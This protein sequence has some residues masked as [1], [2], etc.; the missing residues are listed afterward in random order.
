MGL[1]DF[2]SAATNTATTAAGAQQAGQYQ[3]TMAQRNQAIQAAMLARQMRME[4]S[5]E[6]YREAQGRRADAAAKYY[7]KRS[8]WGPPGAKGGRTAVLPDNTQIE[9]D[10]KNPGHWFKTVMEP[11]PE[12]APGQQSPAGASQQPGGAPSPATPP[13]T[14]GKPKPSTNTPGGNIAL[15]PPPP[16]PQYGA[17]VVTVNPDGTRTYGIP[18]RQEP[19][20]IE[21]TTGAPD[22]NAAGQGPQV[23]VEDMQRLYDKVEKFS[24]LYKQNPGIV[25]RASQQREGLDYGIA[26]SSS[27]GKTAIGKS[28]LAGASDY[29]SKIGIP[30]ANTD[31]TTA[32]GKQ[33][34][35]YKEYMTNHRAL[36]DDIAK[37]FR[38]RQNEQAV[39][40]EIAM[41][42]FQP[43]DTP[44]QIDDKL[45][46][47][48]NVIALAERT[49]TQPK[50]QGAHSPTATSGGG[51]TQVTGSPQG[52]GSAK[53]AKKNWKEV[54]QSG[55]P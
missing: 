43:G 10:P 16:P 52:T 6:A 47:M 9:E 38:G 54:L 44:Q 50:D 14:M 29:A 42:M 15:R 34:Q 1:L 28:L 25:N 4:Q 5:Q 21:T 19:K 41:A 26:R 23:P 40:R 53:P 36:G 24:Q 31:T 11:S 55:K 22:R 51:G 12:S 39:T 27:E 8:E 2:L 46:R 45:A 13:P 20:I 3:A 48:R 17:P 30:T 33:Y 49:Q 7:E 18:S 32:A 37:V 35:A